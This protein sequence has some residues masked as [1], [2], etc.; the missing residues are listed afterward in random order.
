MRSDAGAS[1]NSRPCLIPIAP[2][3]RPAAARGEARTSL[4]HGFFHRRF[5]GESADRAR[6]R[7]GHRT[8]RRRR[9]LTVGSRRP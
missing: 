5:P 7:G 3:G 6:P 4:T 9:S 2:H 8:D 1:A